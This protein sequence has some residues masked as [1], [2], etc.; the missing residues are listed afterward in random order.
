MQGAAI[1]EVAFVDGA[2]PDVPVLLAGIPSSV[3]AFVLDE[4]T[5]ALAQM[6]SALAGRTGIKAIHLFSHGSPGA[7]HL[8][9]ARLSAQT[10]DAHQAGL[11]ALGAALVDGGDLLLMAATWRKVQRAGD[12][13]SNRP[14]DLY[15]G[16]RI[17]RQGGR[18]GARR[19][20]AT[21]CVHP[22]ARHF[23]DRDRRL[24]ECALSN[25]GHGGCRHADGN[26]W[27]RRDR[28]RRGCRHAGRRRR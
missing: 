25:R 8:I 16:R 3:Q 1:R 11:L 4:R 19:K 17:E 15:C 5:D 26:R 23:P 18:G 22:A 7:L 20:L 10:L 21:R 12:S 9:D 6:R 13:S 14:L 28:R 2:L 24:C 27:R